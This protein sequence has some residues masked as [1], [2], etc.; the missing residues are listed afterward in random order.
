MYVNHADKCRFTKGSVI[1]ESLRTGK[2]TDHRLSLIAT[3][4]VLRYQDWLIP[5]GVRAVPVPFGRMVSMNPP[6][7]N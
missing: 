3:E 5:A 6:I 7:A 1:K 4:E 2:V